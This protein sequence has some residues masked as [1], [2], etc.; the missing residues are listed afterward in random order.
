MKLKFIFSALC[1]ITFT[2]YTQAQVIEVVGKG[3][4]NNAITDLTFTDV[5]TI[6]YIVVEAVYKSA[7]A[8]NGPV[9]F[10]SATQTISVDAA[11]VEF[12]YTAD[13]TDYGVHP[14]YFRTTM[15]PA[16]SISLYSLNNAAGIHS[17]VAYVY[18]TLPNAGYY[19]ERNDEHGFFYRNGEYAPG[20]FNIPINTAQDDRDI[21]VTAVISE[22]AFDTRLCIIDI[23]AGNR[24]ANL[25]LT[26]PNSG[27]NLTLEPVT[28]LDVAGDVDNVIVS[29]YSPAG[30]G[31]GDSF[32]SGN[33]VVDVEEAMIDPCLNSDLN[34]DLGD[35]QIVYYG[36]NPMAY[37]TIDANATG[38]I[39]PYSYSWSNGS[40]STSICVNPH[41]DTYYTVTVTD[42]NGCVTTDEILVE[43]IDVRCG[44]CNNNMVKV[45]HTS[46][47]CPNFQYTLCVKSWL[48]PA[49]L[50]WGDQLGSCDLYKSAPIDGEMP[51]FE[52]ELDI[53]E[54]DKKVYNEYFKNGG[55]GNMESSL[56]IYPN[57]IVNSATIEF[58]VVENNY[59][60]VELYDMMGRRI[61]Q[62]F[63]GETQVGE[64]Y[65]LIFEVSEQPQGVYF[66]ILKNG[67]NTIKEKVNIK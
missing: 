45:C 34:V 4:Y 62:L 58:S 54:Y 19:S 48:V 60:T 36:Y 18:R 44:W 63:A 47:W 16:S 15:D 17:F 14:S 9:E 42:A 7:T 43:V 32:I 65:N 21:T 51:E 50:C 49:L 28:L 5:G 41:T 26:Q 67:E 25:T 55:L 39:P 38:G 8:V 35:D 37:A 29:I 30:W 22:L 23:T 12:V 46:F 52:T 11:P 31:V 57:P 10:I 13:G 3:A 59:T 64:T 66:L 20:V 6:D 1:V 27:A 53:R 56:S 2:F 61:T 33:I 40:T 24:T